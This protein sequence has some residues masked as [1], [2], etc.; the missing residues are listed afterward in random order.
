[1]ME[2][3]EARKALFLV[4]KGRFE[5]LVKEAQSLGIEVYA[6]SDCCGCSRGFFGIYDEEA[7]PIDGQYVRIYDTEASNAPQAE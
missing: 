5:G 1:M 2:K 3:S 4:Y 6:G 7:D